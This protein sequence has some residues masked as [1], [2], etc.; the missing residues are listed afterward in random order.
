M[1]DLRVEADK[2]NIQE[3]LR[4]VRSLRKAHRNDDD[5][6]VKL[7]WHETNLKMKLEKLNEQENKS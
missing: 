3:E 5:M 6:R 7:N 1:I 4:A 2:Q